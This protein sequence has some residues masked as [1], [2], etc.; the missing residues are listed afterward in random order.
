MK[1]AICPLLLLAIAPGQALAADAAAV[2]RRVESLGGKVQYDAWKQAVGVD[3]LDCPATDADVK[4]LTALAG[5]RE[6]SLWGPDIH[7]D[8]VQRLESLP[9]L[10]TLVLENTEL[11][12]AG[13]ETVATFR[14]LKSLG[15][16]RSNITDAGLAVL[17]RLTNWNRFRCRSITSPTTA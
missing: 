7:D 8:G 4:R 6:L 11:T 12:D 17:S 1:C 5:L 3:L 14:R 16:R 15:L 2:I 13:L 9:R 10:T